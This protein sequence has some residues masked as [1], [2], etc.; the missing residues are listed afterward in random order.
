MLWLED[1]DSIE[2][3]TL[4]LFS[5]RFC[6]VFLKNSCFLKSTDLE[7]EGLSWVFFVELEGDVAC[8]ELARLVDWLLSADKDNSKF[9]STLLRILTPH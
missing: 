9:R 3:K 8:D 7:L 1:I 4:F 6:L 5:L 2:E